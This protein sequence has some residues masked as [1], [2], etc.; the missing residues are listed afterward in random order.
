MLINNRTNYTR[1]KRMFLAFINVYLIQVTRNILWTLLGQ[2]C[3]VSFPFNRS[4]VS[5]RQEFHV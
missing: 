2:T 3:T 5:N 1:T 4:P